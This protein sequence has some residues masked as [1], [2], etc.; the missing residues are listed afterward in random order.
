MFNKEFL[1][2]LT[3][4]YV[5][6]DVSI[7]TSLGNILKKVFKEVITCEDGK[8][9]VANYLLYTN[10]MD[11][12]FDAIIS[13]IN[14]PN[15]NGLE[16]VEEIRKYNEEIPVV[17]TTAHGEANYLMDAI[18][19]NVSGY[20]LK[21][22]DTKELL[23]TVQKFCQIKRNQ[24]LI[25]EKEAELSEYM[26]LMD[27]IATIVKVDQKDMII[28]TN[29]YFDAVSDYEENELVDSNVIITIHPDSTTTHYVKMQETVKKGE[30]WTG[31]I[32]YITSKKESFHLRVTA[33]PKKDS[34]TGNLMGYTAIGFLAD[35]EEQEK[36]ETMNKVRQNILE[37]RQKVLLLSK[38]V[39]KLRNKPAP[40]ATSGPDASFIKS[41]LETQMKKTSSQEKQ[42]AA[43]EQEINALK[44]K[45]I[46]IADTE[47]AKRRTTLEQ[48]HE[49]KKENNTL[50]NN[51]IA[52]QNELNA[53]KP[54][55]KFVE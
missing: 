14:M 29:S 12:E 8:E 34:N 36:Q 37:Q 2:T 49:L 3:V 48:V 42:L 15:L 50:R 40:V 53:S 51:L 30:T 46:N 33:I 38:E 6:D 47:M 13:D 24:K 31:K 39:K 5:E 43:Y 45:L 44:H 23:M 20:S 16:M 35:D 22:I 17:M 18:K 19:V 41:A 1:K 21:P 28:S 11:I 27:G 7:R 52:V 4:M 32:K 9:G 25:Q 26:E 54:H 10:D 55:P